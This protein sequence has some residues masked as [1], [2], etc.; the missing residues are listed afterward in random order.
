M[1]QQS[2]GCRLCKHPAR[3]AD[4]TPY[5]C[6]KSCNIRSKGLINTCFEPRESTKLICSSASTCQHAG[7]YRACYTEYED[8]VPC[9]A[10]EVKE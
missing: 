10:Y 3:R 1:A 8:D 9:I 7:E 2:Y 4:D 5:H 6:N